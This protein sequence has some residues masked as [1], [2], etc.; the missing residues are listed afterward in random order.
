MSSSYSFRQSTSSSQRGP[1]GMGSRAFY[2]A[3]SVHGGYGGVTVSSAR[4]VSSGFGGGQGGGYGGGFGSS[5][6][7][8]SYGGGFG[9]GGGGAGFGGSFGGVSV[10]GGGLL[11]GSEKETMQNLNDRL[12]SYLDRVRSLEVA[13]TDLEQKIREWYE[14][15]GPSPTRDYSHYFKTIEELKEKIFNATVD[16]A[17]VVL[18][19]DN[20]RLAADDFRS[21]FENEQ[22][23]RLNVEQDINGLRRVL[24]E[25]TLSRTDLEMQI[26]NLKEELAYLKKNHEEELGAMS[27]QVGG[28]VSVEVDAAPSVDLGRILSEMREQY[29][30]MADKSRRE[31]EEWFFTKTEELNKEVASHTQEVQTSRTEI[32]DLRRTMQGLEIELQ[33]QLSMKA[34]L[35]GTLAETEARYGAQLQQIQGMISHIEAQLGDLRSDMERQNQEYKMLMDIKNRLEM[36]IATYRQLL[37]GGDTQILGGGGSQSKEGSKSGG[38]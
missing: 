27:G 12:G 16:N 30:K 4:L 9:S 2:K 33:S 15:Q 31:A 34:S 23:L 38:K 29:E 5:S 18:Q 14:K 26:E 25:L 36:E 3:P 35:E 10:S 28:Q 17:K 22:A 8:G 20:A 11:G 24:D 32:T 19:V 7:G 6:G 37:E 1:G 21:K 13:N